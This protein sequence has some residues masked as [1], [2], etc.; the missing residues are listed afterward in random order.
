VQKK[1]PTYK[2]VK[3][4]T[5][6]NMQKFNEYVNHHYREAKGLEED[7]V[8]NSF[9]VRHHF[10]FIFTL[11]VIVM[12]GCRWCMAPNCSQRFAYT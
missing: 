8:F 1:D 3:E 10:I 2:D 9:T 6:W 7:W 12:S 5:A 4:D 11:S